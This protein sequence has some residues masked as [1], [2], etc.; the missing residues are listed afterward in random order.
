MKL[1]SLIIFLQF[2]ST[3]GANGV[4]YCE[5][6]LCQTGAKHIGCNHAGRFDA[7][8]PADSAL[9]AFANAEIQ[10]IL[11]THNTLRNRIAVGAEVGFKSASKMIMLVSA[12]AIFLSN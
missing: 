6:S 11:D 8:C 3:L 12:A 7:A 9:I 5:P 10:Q 1:V 2:I 4:N